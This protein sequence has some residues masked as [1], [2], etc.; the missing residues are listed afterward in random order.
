MHFLSE[1]VRWVWGDHQ[2]EAIIAA[3]VVV[4][5]VGLRELFRPGS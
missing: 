4:V 3:A 5:A 2:T 1:I